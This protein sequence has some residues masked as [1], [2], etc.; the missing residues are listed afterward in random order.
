MH[1]PV[2]N[3]NELLIGRD[4]IHYIYFLTIYLPEPTF[5]VCSDNFNKQFDL[6]QA[7]QNVEPDMDPNCLTL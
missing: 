7:P 3:K 5:V 6:D 4:G 1:T 2:L